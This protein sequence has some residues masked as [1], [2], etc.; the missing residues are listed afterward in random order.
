MYVSSKNLLPCAASDIWQTET[1]E[2]KPIASFS[3]DE[4][5]NFLNIA[6]DSDHFG[7]GKWLCE[8]PI[9]GSRSYAFSAKAQTVGAEMNDVYAL[10]TV[11]A[12]DGSMLIREHIEECQRQGDVFHF[13]G[14]IDAPVGSDRL[15][16][17]LWLKGY[18][19]SVRWSIPHVSEREPEKPRRVRIALAFIAPGC[20][21]DP[22]LE[23]NRDMILRAVDNAGACDPDIIVL[24]EAMYDR[25][26]GLPLSE[27]A[28]T[29]TGS[30]C[31]LMRQKAQE[32]S[33]YIIYNLHEIDGGEYFNTSILFDRKGDIVGKY[34]KTQLTVSEL[35]KGMTPG[36]ESP[37]FDTDFGR[38]GILICYDHYF[39]HT[40]TI[41]ADKGAEIIFMS[42]AG[43]AE[44][45][46]SARAMDNGIYCAV[47]GMNQENRYGWGPARVVGPDGRI[48]AQSDK[49]TLPA[50][51]DIDLNKPRR[52]YWL[53][54][55]PAWSECKTVYRYERNN[56]IDL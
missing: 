56:R 50:V 54:V 48:L 45:K 12:K 10:Y 25:G 33:S 52:R 35:E 18:H 29:D 15:R 21:P 3:R 6:L 1:P 30:M 43:D 40:T 9:E 7:V 8:I 39:P 2:I 27:T 31:M 22:T 47:C 24:G 26:T 55:G 4:E 16:I 42:S 20:V 34:R 46:L 11:L 23:K 19:C 51:C 53:S 14:P 5:N 49:N 28:E 32:Y 44:E 13:S 36:H 41:L 38:I 17:E 37:V